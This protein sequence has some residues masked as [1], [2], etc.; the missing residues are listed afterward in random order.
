M[1]LKLKPP[2]RCVKLKKCYNRSKHGRTLVESE[3]L[4]GR[5]STIRNEEA[6][7]N[8]RRIAMEVRR[9]RIREI[10]YGLWISIGLVYSILMEDLCMRRLSAKF[11]PKMLAEQQKQL[12]I[13][14]AQGMLD[15]ANH[16][17][18]FIMMRHVFMV[19]S[20]KP[21]SSLTNGSICHHQDSKKERVM[22]R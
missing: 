18:N 5:P 2:R 12:R 19:T 22:W 11:L 20:R 21:S 13:E 6:V 8:V 17:Q 15:W 14:I 7:E 10:A 4:L 3:D 9:V 1:I 16:A